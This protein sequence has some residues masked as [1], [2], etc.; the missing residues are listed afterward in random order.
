MNALYRRGGKR[1]FDVAAVIVSL[2]FVLPIAAIVAVF[3]WFKLGSPI[4]FRQERPG[5]KMRAFHLVK[6]RTMTDLRDENGELLS[7]SERLTHFGAFLRKTSLDEIPE[8]WNVLKGDIGLVGP[9]PMLFSYFVDNKP[10]HLSRHAVRPGITG[11]AQVNGRNSLPY[12]RRFELDNW[13]VEN[14]SLKI[15]LK[16]LFMT[17]AQ[18]FKTE[19]VALWEPEI[20]DLGL[21]SKSAR[22]FP[23]TTEPGG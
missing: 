23:D 4:L 8:L 11:W 9:R 7:D 19:D 3:V 12:K 20:D 18:L 22:N 15:D 14:L 2:P 5:L 17:I 1:L 13:Y 21:K 16:I 10:E 6:F